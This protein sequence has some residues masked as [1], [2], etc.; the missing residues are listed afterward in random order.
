MTKNG[1]FI[2]LPNVSEGLWQGDLL[3]VV[4]LTRKLTPSHRKLWSGW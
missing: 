2:N 1:P 4:D 3:I